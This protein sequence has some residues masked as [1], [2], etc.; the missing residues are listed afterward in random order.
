MAA[1]R[2]CLRSFKVGHCNLSSMA[3]TLWYREQSPQ[4]YLAAFHWTFS[5]DCISE[6]VYGDQTVQQNSKIGLTKV[7]YN[8]PLTGIGQQLKLR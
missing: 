5:K 8:L 6:I 7:V 2:W 4:T 3:V 1:I